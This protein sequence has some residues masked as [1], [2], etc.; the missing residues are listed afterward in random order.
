[1]EEV[2]QACQTISVED[3][4]IQDKLI[5]TP[6]PMSSSTLIQYK[7]SHP[8]MVQISIYNPQG[9]L[10]EKVEQGQPKGEQQIL[11]NAKGLP[12]GM[13]YFRIQAGDKVGSGKI[14]K[15]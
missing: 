2:E 8:G 12:A 13:Y 6:N 14:I 7:V 9:K 11:W 1:V 5:I 15:Y 4:E 3:L 10:I